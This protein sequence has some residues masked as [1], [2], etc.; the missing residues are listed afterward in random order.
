MTENKFNIK[1][2]KQNGQTISILIEKPI[3]NKLRYQWQISEFQGDQK[4][5][6][7]LWKK[8]L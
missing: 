8:F 6:E 5:F 4:D 3:E 1:Y 2:F 7:F